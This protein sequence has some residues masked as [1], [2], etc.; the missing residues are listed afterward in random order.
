MQIRSVSILAALLGLLV[1]CVGCS[2]GVLESPPPQAAADLIL[3]HGKV[4]TVDK[5]FTIRQ[6]VAVRAGRIVKVG[7]D[8]DVLAM[9]GPETTVVDLQ[10]KTVTPGLIDSHVHPDAAMTEFDHPVPEME[11]VQDVLDYIGKRAD[12]LKDGEWIQVSQ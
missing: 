11:S 2:S 10:G 1:K 7:S 3:H 8:A 5:D 6:A 12:A 9:K 4:V